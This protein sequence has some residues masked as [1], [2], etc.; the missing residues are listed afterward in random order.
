MPNAELLEFFKTNTQEI[1]ETTGKW[2]ELPNKAMNALESMKPGELQRRVLAGE[3]INVILG[4]A[5]TIESTPELDSFVDEYAPKLNDLVKR[6]REE[7]AINF[8]ND[9]LVL[10][11]EQFSDDQLVLARK[12]IFDG[13][14]YAQGHLLDEGALS[15]LPNGDRLKSYGGLSAGID[16]MRADLEAGQVTGRGETIARCFGF[17]KMELLS[18]K[19]VERAAGQQLTAVMRQSFRPDRRFASPADPEIMAIQTSIVQVLL[20]R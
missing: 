20:P 19:A 10:A 4:L 6:G 13:R 1:P 14:S 3:D 9:S 16:L 12:K 8:S 5:V 2:F 11:T 15:S 17:A 18:R 7:E